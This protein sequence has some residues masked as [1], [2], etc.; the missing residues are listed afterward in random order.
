MIIVRKQAT[1]WRYFGLQEIILF[2]FT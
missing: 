2:H 1:F